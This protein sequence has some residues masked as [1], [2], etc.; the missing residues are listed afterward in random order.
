MAEITAGSGLG[1]FDSNSLNLGRGTTGQA[2]ELLAVNIA[3]GNLI[4]QRADQ[5]LASVG[6]NAEILR[7]YNSQ[8]RFTDANGDNFRFS[9]SQSLF[10]NNGSSVSPEKDEVFRTDG[11]GN[12][13]RY[14]K[15]DNGRF[16]VSTDGAGA[17]DTLQ[18][19]QPLGV[20]EWIWIEGSSQ[21]GEI[22]DDAGRLIALLDREGVA[23]Y[24]ETLSLTELSELPLADRN[25]VLPATHIYYDDSGRVARIEDPSGQVITLQYAN[26]TSSNVT[27]VLTRS[28]NGQSTWVRYAYDADDRLIQVVVDLS[29]YDNDVSDG[30]V[31][32]TDYAYDGGSKRI[33]SISQSDGTQV[34]VT[35]VEDPDSG[36]FLVKT[37]TRG[38]GDDREIQHFDY[39][40]ADKRT[41]VTQVVNV[42]AYSPTNPDQL[43]SG[44]VV[45]LTTSVFYDDDGQVVRTLAP[46]QVNNQRVVNEYRYDADGNLVEFVAGNGRLSRAR[47]TTIHA[48]STCTPKN[49]SAAASPLSM[50][51]TITPAIPAIADA[52]GPWVRPIHSS[53]S[54]A[55]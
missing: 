22:Y 38:T 42:A 51:A 55:K 37:I 15:D 5:Y 36:E 40:L 1:R 49:V 17:H 23:A 12:T 4:S 3:N 52:A 50:P 10:G 6:F 25:A 2:G 24:S 45:G 16:Y 26:A 48:G 46:P 7:T 53:G 32:T 9:F 8:G 13:S 21:T 19:I 43:V 44:N 34:A 28:A 33:A 30:D 31:F 47:V 41:D 35:Y 14:T 29:P 18:F 27:A 54:G 39:D 20:K 11:D